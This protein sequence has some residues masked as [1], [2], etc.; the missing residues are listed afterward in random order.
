MKN[1]ILTL[2][3]SLF[4]V[5]CLDYTQYVTIDEDKNVTVV[6]IVTISKSLIELAAYSEGY[7]NGVPDYYY[8]EILKDMENEARGSYPRNFKF[9]HINND[10][11]I[12]LYVNGIIKERDVTEDIN[13]LLPIRN[14]NKFLFMPFK[15]YQN[16]SEYREYESMYSS[17][18]MKL[19]V[20]KD[21]IPTVSSCYLSSYDDI[22]DV[23]V[24]DLKD[25]FL[26][27][28]PIFSGIDS[29]VLYIEL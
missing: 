4:F 6:A 27:E 15:D 11:E 3:L 28:I 20:S 18:K 22:K 19:I 7:E 2:F 25:A 26:I 8:E 5:S 24:Y 14:G 9:K 1:I 21:Y 17:M 12:G 23:N 16:T 29:P 13:S 10:N